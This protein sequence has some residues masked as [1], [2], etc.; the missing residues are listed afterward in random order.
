MPAK[1][2]S[3]LIKPSLLLE[4]ASHAAMGVALGLGFA[5]LETHLTALGVTT[6]I[7]YSRAPDTLRLMFVVACTVGFGIGAALTGA[8]IT[9]TET[10]DA[11]RSE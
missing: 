1:R 9:L 2:R 3:A 8:A 7:S 10:S 11:E 6:L 5:F 4:L